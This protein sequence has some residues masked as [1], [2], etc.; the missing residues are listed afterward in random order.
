MDLRD[1][2]ALQASLETAGFQPTIPTY[3]LAE[4]VLVYMEPHE[5]AALLKHL[6]QQL[7]SAVCVVYE[8]VNPYCP[9]CFAH[10]A[11]HAI[12]LTRFTLPS[13]VYCHSWD[14]QCSIELWPRV[15]TAKEVL[16]CIEAR[17]VCVHQFW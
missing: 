17:C 10:T 7:P 16:R 1:L 3:V 11:C 4:C 9:L 14:M 13:S 8:Q 15:H 12:D 2:G 5:S 6:G